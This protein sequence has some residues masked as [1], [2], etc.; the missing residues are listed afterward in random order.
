MSVS[1]LGL[2]DLAFTGF[3][4]ASPP[5][6]GSGGKSAPASTARPPFVSDQRPC[7]ASARH[8]RAFRSNFALFAA[9]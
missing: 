8:P 6:A 5:L 2:S 4:S 9:L 1:P 3:T 7:P